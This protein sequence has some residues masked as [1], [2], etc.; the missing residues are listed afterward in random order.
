MQQLFRERS[1][2]RSLAAGAL[3]LIALPFVSSCSSSSSTVNNGLLPLPT[4]PPNAAFRQ[5]VVNSVTLPTDQTT[6]AVD[7]N[8]DSTADNRYGAIVAAFAGAG[9]DSQGVMTQAIASGNEILLIRQGSSD[10]T[11]QKDAC[12]TATI[13]AGVPM[14]SPDFSGSG[15]FA[16]APSPAVQFAGALAAGAF[17]ASGNPAMTAGIVVQLPIGGVL[18]PVTLVAAQVKYTITASGLLSG[19]LNGAILASDLPAIVS[20]ASTGINSG[21]TIDPALFTPDVQLYDPVTG[22]YAPNAANTNPD[23]LS[24]GFGFTAVDATF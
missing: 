23:S 14:A 16:A 3:A 20:A 7:L 9:I 1:F 24:V 19:Q 11:F 6:F 22:A 13:Q 15:V 8:G 2:P 18:V 4:C 10:T 12:A 21:V 5:F 17:Q